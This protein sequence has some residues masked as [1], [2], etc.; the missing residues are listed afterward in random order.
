MKYFS[1]VDK[2][3]CYFALSKIDNSH[4][5]TT[6]PYLVFEDEKHQTKTDTKISQPLT[7]IIL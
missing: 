4:F 2:I 6:K 5:A 1:T 3:Q 7:N